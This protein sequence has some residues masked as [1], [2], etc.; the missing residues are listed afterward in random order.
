MKFISVR[1]GDAISN[2]AADEVRSY[3]LEKVLKSR[4]IKEHFCVTVEM[5]PLKQLDKESFGVVVEVCERFNWD[6][7]TFEEASSALKILET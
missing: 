2:F 4:S 5:K 6:F 3:R 7:D 1:K